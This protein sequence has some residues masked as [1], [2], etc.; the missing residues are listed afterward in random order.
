MD[1]QLEPRRQR[2]RVTLLVWRARVESQAHGTKEEAGA[3]QT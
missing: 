3:Q 1:I 2:L